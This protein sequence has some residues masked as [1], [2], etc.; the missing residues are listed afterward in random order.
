MLEALAASDCRPRRRSIRLDGWRLGELTLVTVPGEL[1]SSLG[2]QISLAATH[3]VIVVGYAGG[4]A[5]YLADREAYKE[6]TYEALASA[7]GPG[8]AERVAS[9]A[10]ELVTS[11]EAGVT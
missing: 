8:S 2:E 5:G 1:F 11:L 9:A 3:P 7:M 4:Y 10:I 6:G